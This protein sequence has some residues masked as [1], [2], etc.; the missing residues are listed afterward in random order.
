M[1]RLE[2]VSNAHGATDTTGSA[3]L[4]KSVKRYVVIFYINEKVGLVVTQAKK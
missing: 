3:S 1:H 2:R 4:C